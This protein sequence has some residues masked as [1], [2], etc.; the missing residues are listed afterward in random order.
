MDPVTVLSQRHKNGR[1]NKDAIDAAMEY[2][3][4]KSSQIKFIWRLARGVAV[5][6][7]VRVEF[8]TKNKGNSG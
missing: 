8:T 1:L 5:D 7:N 2:F 6:T 3:P 4:F